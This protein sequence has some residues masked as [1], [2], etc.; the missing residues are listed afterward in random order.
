M[1]L[2]KLKAETERKNALLSCCRLY[3]IRLRNASYHRQ[4]TSTAL[5]LLSKEIKNDWMATK[6]SRTPSP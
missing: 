6:P 2:A 4:P 1:H 3:A 5:L